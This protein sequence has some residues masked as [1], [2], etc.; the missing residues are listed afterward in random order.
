MRIRDARP[1][2]YYRS[3]GCFQTPAALPPPVDDGKHRGNEE[4]RGESRK[5]QA[6]DHRAAERSILLAAFTETDGQWNHPDNHRERGHDDRANAHKSRFERS[7]PGGLSFLHLL[8]R[9]RSEE[10]RVGKERTS[11]WATDR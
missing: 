8:A 11:R 10:R 6:A 7:L 5:N 2:R 9:E 4:Q 1:S 3:G